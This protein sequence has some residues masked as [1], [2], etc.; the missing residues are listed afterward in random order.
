MTS[1][2]SSDPYISNRGRK[3]TRPAFYFDFANDDAAG[4]AVVDRFGNAR[5]LALQGT[6]GTSWS[7]YRGYWAPN[8][9]DQ[10]AIT[11]PSGDAS[12]A[13]GGENYAVQSVFADGVLTPGG[14]CILAYAMR[15]S[16]TFPSVANECVVQLG[17]NAT[18][19]AG[20]SITH[21]S[22]AGAQLS[23]NNRGV[24]ASALTFNSFAAVLPPAD[25]LF[26]VL[27]HL[28]HLED[29]LRIDAW[30]N[31]VAAGS[32][33]DALWTANGGTTPERSVFAMPDGLTVAAQRTNTNPANPTWA[34]RLGA[35]TSA[36]TRLAYL[37]GINLATA[38]AALA[39][40]LALEMFQYPRSVGEILAGI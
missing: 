35:N 16:G 2:V 37:A 27:V 40:D 15:W 17:R 21:S 26:T 36:G 14:S 12:D 19:S 18:T 33:K 24:G 22:A 1:K 23:I 20:V 9:S 38:D 25:A 28:A 6:L 4:T 39:S 5:A 32:Q 7:S 29:G 11:N 30:I 10:H 13:V 31:A 34:Q 8:G 3:P